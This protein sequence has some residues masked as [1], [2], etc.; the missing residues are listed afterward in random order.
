MS[1][2]FNGASSFNQPLNA[3]N[4]SKVTDMGGMFYGASSFNQPLNEWDTSEVT[5]MWGMFF[6]ADNMISA[7]IPGGDFGYDFVHLAPT[8]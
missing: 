3:W 8:D 1:C 6:E 4:T 5:N 7:N 2:M